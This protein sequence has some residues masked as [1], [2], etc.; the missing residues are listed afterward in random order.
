MEW[1]LQFVTIVNVSSN[2]RDIS[3]GLM[4]A[5]QQRMS[6]GRRLMVFHIARG[7]CLPSRFMRRFRQGGLEEKL[8]K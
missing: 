2:H 7:Y 3:L 8:A 5:N 6:R 4:L 1:N